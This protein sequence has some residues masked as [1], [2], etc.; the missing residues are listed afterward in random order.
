MNPD[1][2][3]FKSEKFNQQLNTV[4]PAGDIGSY[5]RYYTSFCNNLIC[6]GGDTNSCEKFDGV[7]T[8]ESLP[9]LRLVERR[10]KHLCWGLRSGEV[11]LLGGRYANNTEL[12]SADR[13]SSKADFTLMLPIV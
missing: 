5:G 3:V 9:S 11:L 10:E 2:R 12:V 7:S 4:C 8:F 1:T 13:T 6:G